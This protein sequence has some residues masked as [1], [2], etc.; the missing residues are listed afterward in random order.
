MMG[1]PDEQVL[2]EARILDDLPLRFEGVDLTG[3]HVSLPPGLEIFIPDDSELVIS[4]SETLVRITR[5]R[6]IR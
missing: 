5:R 4:K 3:F 2:I 1:A 6:K